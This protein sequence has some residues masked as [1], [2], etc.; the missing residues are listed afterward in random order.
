MPPSGPAPPD[1]G[2]APGQPQAWAWYAPLVCDPAAAHVMDWTTLSDYCVDGSS[3]GGPCT[4][5][6]DCPGG[7]CGS[8]GVIHLYHQAIITSRM[9]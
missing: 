8:D 7:S 1:C 3:D 9:A 2:P 6:G 5:D 4:G